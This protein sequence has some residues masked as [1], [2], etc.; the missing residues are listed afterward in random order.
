M[1][2]LKQTLFLLLSLPIA[3]QHLTLK[4]CESQFVDKN[5][6]LLATH[7]N[8]DIADAQVVQSKIWDLPQV[9]FEI[10]AWSPNTD[11]KFFNVGKEGEKSAYIQQLIHIGGQRKHQIALSKANAEI[12]KLDFDQLLRELKFQLRTGYFTIYFD[13]QSITEIDK[14][15]TNLKSLIDAYSVQT[16]KGNVSLKDLVR[17]QNLYLSLKNDRMNLMNDIIENKKMVLLLLNTTDNDFKPTPTSEEIQKYQNQILYKLEQL[18]TMAL[19]NRPDFLR[20]QKIIDA[21]N[22]NIKLQ[23]SLA[24]PDVTLGAS[25]DQRGGAFNNQTNLTLGVPLPLWNKN[26]GN[27]KIAKLL[28]E[29]DKMQKDQKTLEVSNEVNA[30]F[31]KY[32]EQKSSFESVRSPIPNDLE[33]VYQGVYT[34]FSKRNISILEFTDFLE[35]YNQSIITLNQIYKSFVSSCEELNYTTA[36]KL[37]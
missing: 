26:K 31:Q 33:T 34:N 36:S 14:Q 13:S 12:T 9:G 32:S 1:R 7:F 11:S 5:L 17:L 15:L 2:F 24:I 27:L 35:S 3:A 28:L 18:Q 10:N 20:S 8:I 6:L 4:E 22:L 30:A 23:K 16:Q 25:Y 37:F 29:Q 21:D 19:E